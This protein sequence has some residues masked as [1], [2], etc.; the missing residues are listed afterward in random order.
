MTMKRILSMLLFLTLCFTC[1]GSA[2]ASTVTPSFTVDNGTTYT[3]TAEEWP[4]GKVYPVYSAPSASSIRGANGKAVVSTNDTVKIFGKVGNWVLIQYNISSGR[5]RIGYI[6]LPSYTKRSTCREMLFDMKQ[7]VTTC[8][9]SVTDDPYASQSILTTLPSG[10]TVYV[11]ATDNL[12]SYI[13]GN[14]FCGFVPSTALSI[15][16]TAT[17]HFASFTA[18]NGQVYDQFC[19]HR[20]EYDASQHVYA[21]TGTYER[22]NASG[23]Q[24]AAPDVGEITY[25]LSQDF[26]AS[27]PESM[28]SNT[29][30]HPTWDL[31][32][33]Y[34]QASLNGFASANI[35]QNFASVTVQYELNEANEICYMEYA[36]VPWG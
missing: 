21:V 35:N 8:A 28:G 18:G 26:L 24:E 11:L 31:Y 13:A 19:I 9:V 14:N 27:M 29:T 23:V 32:Q 22:T 25:S 36:A 16:G 5:N 10:C 34:E 12:W 3:A 1:C 4:D 17:H 6:Q 30:L 33:W 7:A 20:L 2:F 15:S